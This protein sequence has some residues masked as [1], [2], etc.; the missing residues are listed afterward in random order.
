MLF[1]GSYDVYK[2]SSNVHKK[3]DIDK[4]QAFLPFWCGEHPCKFITQYG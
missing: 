3:T 4:C 1:M 2:P